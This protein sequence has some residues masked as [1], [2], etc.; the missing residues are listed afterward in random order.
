MSQRIV[1]LGATSAIATACARRWAAMGAQLFLVGRDTTKLSQT[2]QDLTL[3]GAASVY[4]YSLDLTDTHQH[5]ALWQAVDAQLHGVDIVLVAHG[6]LPDQAACERDAELTLHEISTNAL[7]VIAVLT[8]LANQL[9]AQ[10]SGS[11]AVISSVA[12]DRGRASNY[13]YGAAKA[14]VTTFC[15]GLRVRLRRCGVH[16][17]T[18]KPGFVATPMTRDLAL[19]TALLA[20][21]ERVAADILRAIQRRK[22]VIYTPYY[23]A[24]IMAII[25]LLPNWLFSRLKL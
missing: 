12:G 25:R 4:C 1:I 3:R 14:A 17:L 9:A 7:S 5:A 22:A 15:S 2:A 8:P 24:V 18:V 6:T 16:V 21:P 23:W 19:P 11:I 10:G 20:T 13:V